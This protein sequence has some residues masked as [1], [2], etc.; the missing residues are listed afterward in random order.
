MTLVFRRIS[1]EDHHYERELLANDE[2]LLS[3]SAATPDRF[4][5]CPGTTL[6]SDSSLVSITAS[7]DTPGSRKDCAELDMRGSKLLH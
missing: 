6:A 2:V 1:C 5:S 4:D 7:N 3:H